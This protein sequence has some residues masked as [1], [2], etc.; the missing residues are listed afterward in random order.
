LAALCFNA[1]FNISR[2]YP[3]IKKL[4]S[5]NNASFRFLK[6]LTGWSQHFSTILSDKKKLLELPSELILDIQ[7][8]A[9]DTVLKQFLESIDEMILNATSEEWKAAL[10]EQ[11]DLLRIFIL[12]RKDTA[13]IPSVS[14]YRP[15]LLDHVIGVIKGQKQISNF[16]EDWHVVAQGLASNNQ[17]TLANELLLALAAIVVNTE[18]LM[19]FIGYYR[20]IASRMKFIEHPDTS[21]NQIFSKLIASTNENA[22]AFIDTHLDDIDASLVSASSDARGAFLET[23]KSHSIGDGPSANRFVAL[24][25]RF[26]IIDD[27]PNSEEDDEPG[28]KIED[29]TS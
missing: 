29:K 14:E 12:R 10:T 25:G 7:S 27:A 16:K 26:G 20:D 2:G 11:N 1:D 5:D 6:K 8:Q 19:Q 15:A 24:R 21:L 17:A 13:L 3:K 22:K 4:V 18:G 23:L 28:D 9:F